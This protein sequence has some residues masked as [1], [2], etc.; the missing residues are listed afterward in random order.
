MSYLIIGD[1]SGHHTL[2][3][4]EQGVKP[5]D[6]Y[7][8]EDSTKGQY[9]VTMEGATVTDNIEDFN[10]MKFDVVVGNPPY[11]DRSGNT[12]KSKDV[13]DKFTLIAAELGDYF[14]LIIRSKHFTNPKSSFRKKLFSTGKVVSIVR[15]PD[16]TFPL[17]QNTET[18]IVT[19]SRT[20]T[21]P[22]KVTYKDGSV[23]EKEL[24]SDTVIKLDN[25]NF[26]AEVENNLSHR[27]FRGKLNRNKFEAGE[28]PIVEICGTGEGPVVN[29]IKEGQE[30]TGRNTWGVVINVAAEWGS[31]GRVMLKPYNA[32]ISSSIMCL[33]TDTE[34]DAIRLQ[35]YLLSDDIKETVKEN[36]PSFHPTKDLFRKI[37]DPLV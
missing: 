18:C 12:S 19:W 22:T 26:V 13:D 31:L 7:V 15:L 35:E 17:V 28:C 8:W 20:H 21:G 30:D 32:S 10:H 5:D 2:N 27:W 1:P 36:M 4:I 33:K 24:T 3:L 23:V 14:S 6:I 16:D 9:A 37:A 11:S 34:Q 29:Y 25:P